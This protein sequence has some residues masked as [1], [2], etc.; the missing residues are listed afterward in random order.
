MSKKTVESQERTADLS[1]IVGQRHTR[2]MR[3]GWAR[4]WEQYSLCG[5]RNNE[6]GDKTSSIRDFALGDNPAEHKILVTDFV[7]DEPRILELAT[8]MARRQFQSVVVEESKKG[9]VVVDGASR[10]AAR[11]LTVAIGK[12]NVVELSNALAEAHASRTIA[13][14]SVIDALKSAKIGGKGEEKLSAH[15]L[16][17]VLDGQ[18]ATIR[19]SV[20]SG[21]DD[22][23]MFEGNVGS[24]ANDPLNVGYR[25]MNLPEAQLAKKSGKPNLAAITT[26]A[27]DG[28]FRAG[29]SRSAVYQ[30]VRECVTVVSQIN[31]KVTREDIAAYWLNGGDRKPGAWA[32]LCKKAGITTVSTNRQDNPDAQVWIAGLTPKTLQESINSY[33]AEEGGNKQAVRSLIDPSGALDGAVKDDVLVDIARLFVCTKGERKAREEAIAKALAAKKAKDKRDKEETQGIKSVGKGARKS[34]KARVAA[35]N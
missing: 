26:A 30:L 6:K 2:D 15:R 22:D 3:P 34:S 27:M 5:E 35:G 21:F 13:D 19:V 1:E 8:S 14:K 12:M 20:Q 23:D 33:D 24:L 31:K 29:D 11:F 18:D 16:K 9:L 25:L 4:L 32:A 17:N 28:G 10:C 7:R